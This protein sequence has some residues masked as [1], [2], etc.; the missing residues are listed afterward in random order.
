M[1]ENHW[2]DDVARLMASPVSRRQALRNAGWLAGVALTALV[3]PGRV[4]AAPATCK[5]DDDCG[6]GQFCCNK[7]VCCSNN[8]TCCGPGA[9]AM[10]CAPGHV[11]CGN[12]AN[13][14]CCGVGQTCENG[15]CKGN[16]SPI[17]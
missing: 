5:S 2:F 4:R 8:E 15:K 13:S 9:N 16:I 12:G 1:S 6:A 17:R 14:V 11:C 10:C 3:A 7:K